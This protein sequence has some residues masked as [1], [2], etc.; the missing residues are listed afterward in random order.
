LNSHSLE[1]AT[2]VWSHPT[3]KYIQ[4]AVGEGRAEEDV[5]RAMMI[6]QDEE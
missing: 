4:M 3:K 1:T 5:V 2:H 6:G